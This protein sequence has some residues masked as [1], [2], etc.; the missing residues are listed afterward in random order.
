MRILFTRHGESEANTQLIISN[1]DLPHHLT[2]TGIAQAA[3]LVQKLAAWPI[4]RVISSPVLRTRETAEIL[5][6]QFNLPVTCADALREFDCGILEGRGDPDAWEA[7][8]STVSAWLDGGNLTYRISADAE[9]FEDIRARF[10]PY[11]EKLIA[12]KSNMSGDILLVSHGGV[13]LLMLPLILTNVDAAF[14]RQHPLNN[15]D[16]VVAEVVDGRLVC[17][18]W[19][20]IDPRMQ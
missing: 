10:I 4:I 3:A 13:L 20:G 2:D 12:E 16:L 6:A 11:L 1:R 8:R 14:V 19:A 18:D 15:C 9:S 17:I 7:L 5:A